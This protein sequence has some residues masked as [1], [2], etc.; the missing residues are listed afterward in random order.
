MKRVRVHGLGIAAAV[1]VGSLLAV[2]VALPITGAPPAVGAAVVPEAVAVTPRPTVAAIAVPKSTHAYGSNIPVT[3]NLLSVEDYPTRNAGSAS[4]LVGLSSPVR[5][6]VVKGN[7]T[8]SA[9]ILSISA[10]NRAVGAT[11]V[12][13]ANVISVGGSLADTLHHGL[14]AQPIS[15]WSRQVS[16]TTWVQV[17]SATTNS[18]GT[19]SYTPGPLTSAAYFQARYPGGHWNAS[20]STAPQVNVSPI[21]TAVAVSTR[22]TF[23]YGSNVTVVSHLHMYAGVPVAGQ[24]VVVWSRDIGST[25][26][27]QV[28]HADTNAAG[29]ASVRAPTVTAT[30]DYQARYAAASGW[31]PSL[32]GAV[33]LF[34]AQSATTTSIAR[35]ASSVAYRHA[36]VLTGVVRDSLR[37]PVT[38]QRVYLWAQTVAGSQT[39]VR[40]AVVLTG[41]T[42]AYSFT[43]KSLIRSTRFQV[44][45]NTVGYWNTSASAAT[46]VVVAAPPAAYH[47]TISV[48]SPAMAL[49]MRPSWRAGCPVPLSHL[50]YLTM[51]YRGFDG[52][53]HTGEMVVAASVAG[54]VVTVFGKLWAARYPIRS[55]RLVDD[56]GGSDDASMNADNTSGFNCRPAT[57]SSTGFSQHSYGQAIDVNTIENPYVNGSHIEPSAGRRYV[58][59]PNLPGVIHGRDVVVKAFA[60]V[61]WYWAGYWT[62][63]KDYQHF[64]ANNR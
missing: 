22:G 50:R 63:F 43:T 4:M 54:K 27:H 21:A 17:G 31:G 23:A 9:A 49:R 29:D 38:V 56:F 2:T 30:R 37:R 46:G 16:S 59:R 28:G 44:R 52:R 15:I 47:S 60:S 58:G 8:L 14:P 24:T 51:T 1:V 40:Q 36:V 18:A 12:T 35:N 53:D 26:W 64:S 39:W 61:G 6:S 19:Y 13:Y 25:T 7:S 11:G 57:G 34:I 5:S 45:F 42:G 41:R 10:A 32:S 62:G 3:G 33:R 55:M 20:I 48:I